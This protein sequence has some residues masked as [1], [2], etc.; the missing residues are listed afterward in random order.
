MRPAADFSAAL[1]LLLATGLVLSRCAQS[2]SWLQNGGAVGSAAFG[3]GFAVGVEEVGLGDSDD[4]SPRVGSSDGDA[5]SAL[6]PAAGGAAAA[7][8]SCPVRP[9]PAATTSATAAA[10]T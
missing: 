7:S 2:G 9:Q 10:S 4:R 5:E 1:T 8:L 6:G 3:F